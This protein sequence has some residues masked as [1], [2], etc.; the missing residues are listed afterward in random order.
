MADSVIAPQKLTILIVDDDEAILQLLDWLLQEA[1]HR[2][3]RAS[4]GQQALM[5]LNRHG[6][7]DVVL[8]D[9]NMP[10]MDGME[11]QRQMRAAWP[12]LPILLTSGRPPPNGIGN[13]LPKPF[14][15]DALANAI[16]RLV[17]QRRGVTGCA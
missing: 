13:F 5:F 4:D 16:M 10:A 2:V 3:H 15:W 17:D 14:R 8:S 6:P 12:G 1:G 7:V 9:I 11:L